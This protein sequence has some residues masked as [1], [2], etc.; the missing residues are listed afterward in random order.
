MGSADADNT[1]ANPSC[2]LEEKLRKL[3]LLADA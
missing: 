1:T 3:K 2:A